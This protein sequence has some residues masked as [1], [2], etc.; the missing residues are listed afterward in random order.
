MLI[1]AIPLQRCKKK[2]KPSAT[3]SLQLFT[4]KDMQ[5]A[6]QN[7]VWMQIWGGSVNIEVGVESCTGATLDLSCTHQ[8]YT[9][10]D[11]GGLSCGQRKVSSPFANLYGFDCIQSC[12]N[13]QKPTVLER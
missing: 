9:Y 11:R 4:Q 5:I 3:L 10:I 7:F 1:V 6:A 13:E 12:I 2:G 8:T